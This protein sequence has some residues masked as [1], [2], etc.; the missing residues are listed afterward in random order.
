MSAAMMACALA[1]AACSGSAA[2]TSTTTPALAPAASQ[3]PATGAAMPSP[4]A[5]YKP[6]SADGPAENVPVPKMP[7]AAKEKSKEGLKAFVTYWY[8]TLN[9]AY[10]TGD[11]GPL[12]DASGPRCAGCQRVEGTI[13]EWHSDGK[14]LGG[15]ELTVVGSVIQRFKSASDGS[16]QV[17]TQVDQEPLYFYLSDGTL[18]Q[19]TERD[20]AIIDVMTAEFVDGVWMAKNVEGMG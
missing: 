14:W 12:H 7:E 9:F 19:Q 15:G 13:S 10:E 5:A 11:L 18:K 4:T 17:V 8:Q 1:L 6:A 20:T 2:G 16:Y 3:P